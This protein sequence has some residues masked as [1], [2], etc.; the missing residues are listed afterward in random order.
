MQQPEYVVFPV[1]GSCKLFIFR[2]P[3][4]VRLHFELCPHCIIFTIFL[5]CLNRIPPCSKEGLELLDAQVVMAAP[6]LLHE[7]VEENQ[8]IVA[9]RISEE[10]G[11]GRVGWVL[12]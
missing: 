11:M 5:H 4:D 12:C 7:V 1:L 2:V 9:G 6:V 8:I 3:L 10:E